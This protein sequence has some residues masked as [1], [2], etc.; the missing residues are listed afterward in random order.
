MKLLTPKF[1]IY[2]IGVISGAAMQMNWMANGSLIT[3]YVLLEAVFR[4][5]AGAF[6]T[7]FAFWRIHLWI[8]KRAGNES[9]KIRFRQLAFWNACSFAPALIV[10]LGIGG[11][12][13]TREFA[14]AIIGAMICLNLL[15]HMLFNSRLSLMNGHGSLGV[16][17]LI[18]G[19]AALIY[20]VSWQRVLFA[21]FGI[22]MESVTLVVSVFMFGLG[23]GSI[24]GGMLSE[25][26]PHRLRE[27]FF[28]CEVIIGVFGLASIGIIRAASDVAVH[29]S[30]L[31]VAVTIFAILCLPTMMMGATL[32]ILVT[33]INRERKNVGSS[34]GWLYFVNT[35]GSALAALLT[36][37]LIFPAIGLQGAVWTA[38]V[39]NFLV[40]LLVIQSTWGRSSVS[41]PESG[42]A[43]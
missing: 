18:S 2:L 33:Y 7:A 42:E 32:P 27:M 22:D 40:A 38:A 28:S 29:G 12:V 9:G 20:Q 16:L 17:F 39:F 23:I 25:R 37:T 43:A 26:F 1:I 19:F 5:V 24:I 8:M 36:V 35:V 6:I 14:V 34:V 11:I 13:M 41:S 15:V 21:T 31:T 4:L 10:L 3:D 30:F